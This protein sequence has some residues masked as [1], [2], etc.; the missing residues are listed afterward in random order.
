MARQVEAFTKIDLAVYA[1]DGTLRTRRPI[2]L[3]GAKYDRLKGSTW[4]L[5]GMQLTI[6]PLL[7]AG[8]R[9]RAGGRLGRLGRG[10]RPS[11]VALTPHAD[12]V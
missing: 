10:V 1:A 7:Y 5:D 6:N 12:G 11:S 4:E 3:V 8:V 9:E 2:L